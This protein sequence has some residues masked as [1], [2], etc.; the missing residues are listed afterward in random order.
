MKA[1]LACAAVL[2]AVLAGTAA[3]RAQDCAPYGFSAAP[4]PTAFTMGYGY[5]KQCFGHH[6]GLCQSCQPHYAPVGPV[7]P[8]SFP[9][10]G[11]CQGPQYPVHP[12]ARSPRDF[13]MF[14]RSQ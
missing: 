4:V 5:T 6:C 11:R 1:T 7:A 2:S 13:F 3:A 10:M 9:M 8:P 14:E 12:F